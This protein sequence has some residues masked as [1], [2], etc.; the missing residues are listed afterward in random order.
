MTDRE[1][2]RFLSSICQRKVKIQK[3][4]ASY[5][6]PVPKIRLIFQKTR[7]G[8]PFYKTRVRILNERVRAHSFTRWDYF[9]DIE[10]IPSKQ[11]TLLRREVQSEIIRIFYTDVIKWTV[12]ILNDEHREFRARRRLNGRSG[13]RLIVFSNYV[14]TTPYTRRVSHTFVTV[15]RAVRTLHCTRFPFLTN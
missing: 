3:P 5:W 7:K 14:H 6:K 1:L 10:M 15:S 2:N 11:N 13:A 12:G 8:F 9:S 4:I